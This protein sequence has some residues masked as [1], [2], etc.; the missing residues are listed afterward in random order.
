MNKPPKLLL[1]VTLHFNER[2]PAL[3]DN[4]L[5]QEF[6]AQCCDGTAKVLSEDVSINLRVGQ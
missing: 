2:R 1:S 6:K 4:G 3:R 5:S